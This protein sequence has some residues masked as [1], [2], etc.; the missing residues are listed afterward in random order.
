MSWLAVCTFKVE[1]ESNK[2]KKNTFKNDTKWNLIQIYI[3][4]ILNKQ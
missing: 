2:F 1:Y 4:S 3:T